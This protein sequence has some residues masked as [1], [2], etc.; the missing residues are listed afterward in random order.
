MYLLDYLG[1]KQKH[2]IWA[3]ALLLNLIIGVINYLTGYEVRVE[4]FYL[5]PIGILCW[6]VSR[7]AGI[8]MSIISTGTTLT[9]NLFAGQVIQNYW[10]ESWNFIV[11]FSIFVIVVYLISSAK[12]IL[13]NN[14]ALTSKLHMSIF[15]NFR[16]N[17]AIF[18]KKQNIIDITKYGYEQY[19]DIIV[20]NVVVKNASGNHRDNETRYNIIR[21]VL[22]KYS[23][24]L[25]MLDIGASQGYYSFRAAHD[26]DCVCVMIEGDNP[27]YPM[28]GK[29]L[30][31]LC[32]ANDSLENIIL[33]NKRVTPDD[34]QR[35]SE[36][37]YF[38]V[39][40][41]L[42]IIHWF[43][44]Q[45][46]EVTDAILNMGSNIIVETPP[47]EHL[48]S[49]EENFIRKSIEKYLVFK[50]AKILGEVPRHTS[51]GKMATIYLIETS[52][53]K[54]ERKFWFHPKNIDDHHTIVSSYRL[55]T[56]TKKPPRVSHLQ[57]DNWKPG[58]N[59]VT[60][61]MYS[62]AYPSRERIKDALERIQDCNHNDWTVNN[63]ILQGNK[64]TLID[65]ND[66]MHGSDGG[67]RC[68]SKVLKA[69]L[70]LISLRNPTKIES[71]FW[72]RLTKIS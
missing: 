27:E 64:L 56:I 34:L 45:W 42:N 10:I 30:L 53:T 19:Q 61:L 68:S 14:K 38:D 33:L 43:G 25:D 48:A 17:F 9:A 67:R 63:M 40:L 6:L 51:G 52:K 72:N 11:H 23:R 58:I 21:K 4:V 29:Q 49:Q 1:K 54:I 26:Y 2:F 18:N 24:P 65:W 41:A 31:D 7:N 70:K 47:Q 3:I 36:C 22:D 37:E 15:S 46:K 44:S 5:L 66:Q 57:P 69:H 59:L 32:H 28:V 8:I 12:I 16:S 20:N 39:V 55:K 13:E 50:N 62:G 35:L 60:F 71:Y